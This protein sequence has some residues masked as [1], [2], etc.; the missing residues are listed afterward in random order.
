MPARNELVIRGNAVGLTASNYPNDSKFEQ[1]ILYLEKNG[2]TYTETLGSTTATIAGADVD[3]G[4]TLTI[5]NRTYTFRTA[6]TGV[7]ATGLLTS[8]ATA[9]TA[10]DTVTINGKTYTFQS[11]LSSPAQANEVLIGISAAVALD[12]LKLA[13]NQGSVAYPT[14]AD[15]SGEGTTWSVGTVRHPDVIATTNTNTTQVVE[16]RE[17]GLRGN[18]FTLAENSTHLAWGAAN[19]GT[20]VTTEVAGVENIADEIKIGSSAAETL[21]FLK[22]AINNTAVTG[23]EGA[24]YSLGTKAHN[25]VTATTNA[26]T[27]QLIV[28]RNSAFDNAS[29][30]TVVTGSGNIAVTG[31]TL[32]SG[33]RG[34]IAANTTTWAGSAGVSGDKNLI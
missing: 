2:T 8:D 24:A 21:D 3:S 26:A 6:L 4:D 29:I 1:K 22:D 13:I 11:T 30:A 28:A 27:T 12:N 33:V 25:Q 17:Y 18:T 34:V 10:G 20:V 19:M 15:S 5:G 32:A 7:K 14:A 31:A 16:A 9:P 23:A